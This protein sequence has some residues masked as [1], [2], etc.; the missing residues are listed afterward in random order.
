LLQPLKISPTPFVFAIR[1][2]DRASIFEKEGNYIRFIATE[3]QE[4]MK[5]WVLSIRCSKVNN[6]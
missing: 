4:E 3:D 5:N 1:A 6:R 2:Q